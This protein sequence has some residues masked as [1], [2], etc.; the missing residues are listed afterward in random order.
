MITDYLNIDLSKELGL[1]TLPDEQRQ[2]LEE[3]MAAVLESRIMNAVFMSL[4]DEDR[5]E[6]E[7]KLDTDDEVIKFL[8]EKI[9]NFEILM[10]EEVANFKKDALALNEAVANERS[11]E[12]PE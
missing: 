4:S 7:K 3:K 10:A 2:S 11:K 8:K 5:V 6:L 9:P 1:D 12:S